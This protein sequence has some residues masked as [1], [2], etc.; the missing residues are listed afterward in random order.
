VQENLWRVIQQVE[1]LLDVF[2]YMGREAARIA[3]IVRVVCDALS[4]EEHNE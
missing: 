1:L 4:V 2:Y 3:E